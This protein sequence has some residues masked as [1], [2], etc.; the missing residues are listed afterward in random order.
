M[1]RDRHD[2]G[3]RDIEFV[4][5]PLD[6]GELLRPVVLAKIGYVAEAIPDEDLIKARTGLVH[7]GTERKNADTRNWIAKCV[8]VVSLAAIFVA[9]LASLITETWAPVAAVW[10][11]C[12]PLIT[13]I[14]GFYFK[15]D[16][17]DPPNGSG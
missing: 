9:G 17:S 14:V 15:L 3:D 10:S 1:S 6:D 2:D 8:I 12:G 11:V 4:A 7:A 5:E 16:D 13:A